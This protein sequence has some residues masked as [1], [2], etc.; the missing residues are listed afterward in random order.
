V[1][2]FPFDEFGQNNAV[3]G[4]A[5]SLE[6]QEH[7]LGDDRFWHAD[8][9]RQDHPEHSVRIP[10]ERRKHGDGSVTN[11]ITSEAFLNPDD[12]RLSGP[13]AVTHTSSGGIRLWTA[14]DTAVFV[15][16][17]PVPATARRGSGS[18]RPRTGSWARDTPRRGASTCSTRPSSA[19][20]WPGRA[21]VHHHQRRGQP[22]RGFHHGE[23][24]DDQD[25]GR[26]SW[27]AR[28]LRRGSVQ[29]VPLGDYSF[30]VTD[31]SGNGVWLATEYI[32]PPASQDPQDN[33]GT[34]VFE[35]SGH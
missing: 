1:N 14:L 31:P 13:V 6:A 4:H 3:A 26:R 8:P 29:P 20:A 16:N 23:L 25:G 7:H 15:G 11:G 35:V 32:P 9:V 27:A 17:D 12:S 34:F 19:A 21:G 28:E 18:T 2:S 10:C 33:W 24:A 22:E 5:G 30:A